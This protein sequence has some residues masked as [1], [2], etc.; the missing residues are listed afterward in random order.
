MWK[1][2]QNTYRYKLK[3]QWGDKELKMYVYEIPSRIYRINHLF[4]CC[5]PERHRR[6]VNQK[7]A[8]LENQ[9]LTR[10]LLITFTKRLSKTLTNDAEQAF[11]R[12][13]AKLGFCT[14]SNK[15]FLMIYARNLEDAFTLAGHWPILLR[16]IQRLLSDKGCL[17]IYQ[18]VPG[19]CQKILTMSVA[20]TAGTLD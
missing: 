16:Q 3:L 1:K 7:V 11:L 13:L 8:H 14:R 17:A 6:R 19:E 2:F 5:R 18:G 9:V 4:S 12:S 15:R 10:L 20:P